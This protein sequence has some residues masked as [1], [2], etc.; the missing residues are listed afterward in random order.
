MCCHCL[1]NHLKHR[2]PTFVNK[3][4]PETISKKQLVQHLVFTLHRLT[5]KWNIKNSYNFHFTLQG[6]YTNFTCQITEDGWAYS[7]YENRCMMF[8]LPWAGRAQLWENYKW[9][10]MSNLVLGLEAWSSK[11]TGFYQA[12]RVGLKTVSSRTFC[13][14]RCYDLIQTHD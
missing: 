1:S 11:D 12:R 2:R 6:H 7:A 8:S 13:N 3:F 4:H 9:H 14:D 10:H 5:V